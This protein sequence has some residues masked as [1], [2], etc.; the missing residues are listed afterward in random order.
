A[1]QKELESTLDFRDRVAY[2]DGLVLL[3]VAEHDGARMK[4]TALFEA[5]AAPRD[6]KFSVHAKMTRAP[7]F[8][9]V[10]RDT[11]ELDVA[12]PPYPPTAFWKDGSL[13][14]LKM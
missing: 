4:L 2:E 6:L 8:S 11:D 9:F 1:L 5:P 10:V 13:Y 14:A 12:A 7:S 3:G